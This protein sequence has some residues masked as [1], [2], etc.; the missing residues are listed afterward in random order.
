[1]SK[2]FLVGNEVSIFPVCAALK[3][4]TT[5]TKIQLGGNV[6]QKTSTT[7]DSY[8]IA[9]LWTEEGQIEEGVPLALAEAL[10]VNKTLVSLSLNS[11][12]TQVF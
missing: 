5:L 12:S 9:V 8:A 2:V 7:R 6:I 1:M 4:N 11:E 3:I 10:A